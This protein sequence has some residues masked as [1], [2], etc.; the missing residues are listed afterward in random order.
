MIY[1]ELLDLSAAL[2]NDAA[3]EQYTDAVLLPFLNISLAELQEMFELNNIPVTNDTSAKLDVAT[4]VNRIAFTGTTPL[5]PTDLI[6]IQ[7]LWCSQDGQ[8]VWLPVDKKEFLTSEELPSGS[9]L[10][11]FSVWAWIEQEIK[12]IAANTPLD[13]KIDY[14]KSL[15]I[16]IVIGGIGAT[17]TTLNITTFLQYRISG[18]VAEF[19]EENMPKANNLNS[20][21][22]MAIDRSLGISIKGKQAIMT[23]RRPFRAAWKQRGIVA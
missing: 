4:G 9:E 15:F 23:R 7:R 19:I 20:F 3:Q 13:L 22:S 17:I 5:L 6:E 12:L 10:S 14:V 1:S 2:L 11:F 16:P 8:N 21:A 18:L